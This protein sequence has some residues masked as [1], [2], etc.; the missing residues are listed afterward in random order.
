[1]GLSWGTSIEV[2]DLEARTTTSGCSRS[3]IIR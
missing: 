2:S 3:N 1:M